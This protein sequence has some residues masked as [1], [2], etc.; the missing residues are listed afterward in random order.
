MS[1]PR[2]FDSPESVMRY[3]IDIAQRGIGRVEP[4]PAVGAILVDESLRLLA[5][6]F[7]EEFGGPHAEINCLADFESRVPNAADRSR[8]IREAT[9]FVTLEPCCHHGKTPPCSNAVIKSG[10]RRCVIGIGD[11]APHVSGGGIQQLREAGCDVSVGLLETDVENLNAPF[12]KLLT[13]GMPWVIAKWASTLDGKIASRSGASKWIS[14]EESRAV[15]H[16]LRGRMDSIMVGSRTARTD[17]PEL[18]ARPAGPRAA[19]RIVIDSQATLGIDSKLVRSASDVPVLV[20]AVESAPEENVR[21][22]ESAGVEVFR[23]GAELDSERADTGAK[24]VDLRIL[25][26]ELAKRSMTNVLVEGG[27]GLLGYLLDHELIDEVHVFIAPKLVGGRNALT[28][29]GGRG[30]DMIP[31]NQSIQSPIVERTGEDI[32]IHGFIARSSE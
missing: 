25:L 22:L 1:E 8:L 11:P 27:S 4:N 3:A 28:P 15:V 9:L 12:L 17:D 13:T 23:C 14:S 21:L 24:R 30:L 10:V 6:G 5:Q 2:R 31:V 20:A 7:H 16:R 29:I 19:T 32:Y 18:T 26:R